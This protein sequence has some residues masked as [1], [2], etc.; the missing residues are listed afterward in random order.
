MD[1]VLGDKTERRRYRSVTSR[2]TADIATCLR[3]VLMTVTSTEFC[4]GA[5]D[6]PAHTST[7]AEG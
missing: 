7:L 5:K 1:D 6:C 4:D 3:E 2:A